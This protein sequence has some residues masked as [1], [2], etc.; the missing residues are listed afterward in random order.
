[1]SDLKSA[2]TRPKLKFQI[3][4]KA[5]PIFED[6]RRYNTLYGGRGSTKSWTIAEILS[7]NGYRE[8]RRILCGREIQNSLEESVY[9]LLIDTQERMGLQDFYTPVKGTIQGMN[10]TQFLFKGLQTMGI[11]KIKSLEGIDDLWLEEAH[12]LSHKSLRTIIPTIRKKGSRIYVSMNPELDD[13]PAYERFISKPS[14]DSH[15][16]KMDYLDNPWF[17]NTELEQERS[18]DYDRDITPDKNMYKHI[19]LGHTLPAVEGAIFAGEVAQFIEQHRNRQIDH[20]PMGKV[21][22]IMDLG[23][24]VM[25]M[26]I[27]Q[28]FANTVNIIAYHEWRNSTYD[29][30]TRQ[31]E[32][33]YP[34]YRWGKIFMPHDASHKDPKTGHSHFRVMEDL[35]WTTAPVEQIGIENYIEK[36]RRMFGQCYIN[37]GNGCDDLMRCLKRFKYKVSDNN[38]DKRMKPDKDDFS[39]GAEAYCYTA[40]VADQLG[41]DDINFQHL[42]KAQRGTYA[43]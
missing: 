30:I 40:V 20:D 37:T 36:G 4:E 24:G 12:V 11:N 21:H 39:H 1:M 26:V 2:V 25:T 8:P 28:R 27:A 31:L 10:G 18:D 19:W 29:K 13:D 22:G 3:P 9:Q 43:G 14:K 41:N 6:P 32:E 7:L 17:E 35:G 33:E 42:N 16:I 5:A 38:P 34:E 23:Y 15:V